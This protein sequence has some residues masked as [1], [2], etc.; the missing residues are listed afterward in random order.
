MML[1]GTKGA[2]SYRSTPRAGS[3]MDSW[4]PSSEEKLGGRKKKR[5]ICELPG[6]G[7]KSSSALSE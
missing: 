3:V 5:S 7:S 2:S 6:F 1:Q 4:K